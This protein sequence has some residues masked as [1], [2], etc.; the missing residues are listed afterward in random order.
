M[1]LKLR[2]VS[3]HLLQLA[4]PPIE[5]DF[6]ARGEPIDVPTYTS[7]PDAAGDKTE[8]PLSAESISTFAGDPQEKDVKA[9]WAQYT[10]AQA[11]LVAAQAEAQLQAQLA[12]G[13]EFEVPDDD[14]TRE[15]FDQIESWL[16]IPVPTN[17]RDRKV[18]YLIHRPILS[19][20][21]IQEIQAQINMLSAG[22][23]VDP[24][25]VA[26]FRKSAENSVGQRLADRLE[27]ATRLLEPLASGPEIP[28]DEDSEGVGDQ[29][30]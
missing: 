17:P 7:N 14:E 15:W 18:F 23:N 22:V 3:T 12:L 13:I 26:L 8:L 4:L 21:E 16:R 2:P 1:T 30:E 27:Q 24:Q 5:D 11:K 29:A 6:R 10:T 9:K 20:L 28:G 19:A 25:Q